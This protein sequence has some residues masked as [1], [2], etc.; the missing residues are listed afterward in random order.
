MLEKV[1]LWEHV[2]SFDANCK[3]LSP[4]HLGLHW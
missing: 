2:L 4:S 1:L 3:F